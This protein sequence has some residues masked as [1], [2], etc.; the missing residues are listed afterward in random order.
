MSTSVYLNILNQVA[1]FKDTIIDLLDLLKNEMKV[2]V[3]T[4]QLL[5]GDANI[6][7]CKI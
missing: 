3:M 2:G 7:Y 4:M 5:V 1:D 6:Q